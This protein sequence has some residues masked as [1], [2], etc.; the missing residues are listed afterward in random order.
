LISKA[1]SLE[2]SRELIGKVEM[3]DELKIKPFDGLYEK[4]NPA[5]VREHLKP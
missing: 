1:Y 5:D 3:T 4:A 2:V